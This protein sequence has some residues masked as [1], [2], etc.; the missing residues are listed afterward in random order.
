MRIYDIIRSLY[1]TG[2]TTYDHFA[3]RMK[4]NKPK[5]EEE[6]Y[7][8]PPCHAADAFAVAAVLLQRSGAYHH[9]LPST[10]SKPHSRVLQVTA[11]QRAEWIKVGAAWRGDGSQVLPPPP[12]SVRQSWQRLWNARESQI[13][14]GGAM[15][16]PAWWR[17]ALTIMCIADEA[18]RDLGF[19]TQPGQK[20]A[21]A[22]VMETPVHELVS[23]YAHRGLNA[24]FPTFAEADRDVVCVLPKSRTPSVGCTMR[25]LSHYVA[26]L[27]PVGLAQANWVIKP[28][29]TEPDVSLSRKPFNLLLVPFPYKVNAAAF[30]AHPAKEDHW[31]W[32]ELNPH[33]CV[34]STPNAR[35]SG[36]VAMNQLWEYI[37]ALISM[38]ERDVGQVHG[39][40]FPE[41][42]LSHSV[43]EEFAIRLKDFRHVELLISGLFDRLNE[44]EH[45]VRRGNF[46][47]MA[48]FY[49]KKDG[50]RGYALSIREKHHRWRLDREQIQTYALGS[51]LDPNRG[52][53]EQLELLNRSLDVF[54]VRGMHT[55]TTLICE[56]LA[57]H[58]PCQELGPVPN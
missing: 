52:W 13:Y 27:P 41:L 5:F 29:E 15:T 45:K 54:V 40:V 22:L 58:D 4:G 37:V 33:W 34:A 39:I 20:S 14:S 43:F 50:E 48:H 21:Q 1:P 31:G 53:W 30:V 35:F 51:A 57:R 26:I 7:R 44:V 9:V 10:D 49:A 28:P 12:P 3:E 18:C 46:A 6:H 24:D 47:A 11:E 56:D 17:D 25:S 42:A 38:A 16:H 36:N 8:D 2:Y 23:E 19:S 32:F 55:V